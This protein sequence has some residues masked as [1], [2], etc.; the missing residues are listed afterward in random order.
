MEMTMVT[1]NVGIVPVPGI[2]RRTRQ[3]TEA[4]GEIYIFV[5]PATSTDRDCI[6]D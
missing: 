5:N 2:C 4:Y 6:S 1:I 3:Y